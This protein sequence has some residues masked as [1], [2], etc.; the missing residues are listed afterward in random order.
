M[1]RPAFHCRV[2]CRCNG[3]RVDPALAFAHIVQ[4]C[5]FPPGAVSPAGAVGLMQVLPG[6][7]GD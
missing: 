7:A 3:W 6:T 1:R 4:E 2:G 5:D